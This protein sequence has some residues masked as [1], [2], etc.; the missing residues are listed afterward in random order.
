MWRGEGTMEGETPSGSWGRGFAS[1]GAGVR[2]GRV[3]KSRF[4]GGGEREVMED[5][6]SSRGWW[7]ELA[8]LSSS[9]NSSSKLSWGM[10][11]KGDETELVS[12]WAE[13][14]AGAASLRAGFLLDGDV[15]SPGLVLPDEAAR[16]WIV[17]LNKVG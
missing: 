13:E 15:D 12:G 6:S 5:F 9:S 8:K 2:W 7:E 17:L 10:S 16:V 11:V 14:F 3:R 4:G 1:E